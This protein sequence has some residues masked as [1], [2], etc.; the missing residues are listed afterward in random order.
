MLI[1][2]LLEWAGPASPTTDVARLLGYVDV[3]QFLASISALREDLAT[4]SDLPGAHWQRALAATE[5][6]HVSDRWGAG[7]E[8]PTTTGFS[9]E[10]T[11]RLIRSI[12]RKLARS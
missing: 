10:E 1:A 8:W 4:L 3:P 9:D 12:Q 11:I 5:L 6:V 2:G 7:V